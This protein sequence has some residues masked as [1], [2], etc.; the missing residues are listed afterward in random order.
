MTMALFRARE[1]TTVPHTCLRF[2]SYAQALR[3]REDIKIYVYTTTISRHRVLCASRGFSKAGSEF[4]GLTFRRLVV[5][6]ARHATT[7]FPL[8]R[9]ISTPVAVDFRFSCFIITTILNTKVFFFFFFFFFTLSLSLYRSI[10]AV[11]MINDSHL[12]REFRT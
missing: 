3:S 12:R 11:R 7:K 9:P 5:V 2:D 6:R 10:Y 8:R 4:P 1:T